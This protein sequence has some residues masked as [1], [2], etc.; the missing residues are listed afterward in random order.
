MCSHKDGST[1]GS[2]PQGMTVPSEAQFCHLQS[3]MKSTEEGDSQWN[4][5]VQRGSPE[6]GWLASQQGVPQGHS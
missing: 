5:A 2:L 1:T 6:G 3:Q 4:T